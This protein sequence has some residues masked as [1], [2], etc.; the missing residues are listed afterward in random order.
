MIAIH[1]DASHHP[2]IDLSILG[3]RKVLQRGCNHADRVITD[4]LRPGEGWREEQRVMIPGDFGG[5]FDHSCNWRV[6]IWWWRWGA[7]SADL[8]SEGRIAAG[9]QE[10]S[11]EGEERGHHEVQ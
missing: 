3:I 11:L 6:G 9:H 8:V 10:G 1:L 7:G 2:N 5:I 4:D